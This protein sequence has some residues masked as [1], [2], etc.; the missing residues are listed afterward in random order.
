SRGGS[1]CPPCRGSSTCRAEGRA[2][3]SNEVPLEE[4]DVL[5]DPRVEL[6]DARVGRDLGRPADGLLGLADV[7]HE[8]FLIA[9]PPRRVAALDLAAREALELLDEL[10]QR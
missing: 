6:L 2:C 5:A 3:S 4:V 9:R 1:R 10:V 8:H 7:A